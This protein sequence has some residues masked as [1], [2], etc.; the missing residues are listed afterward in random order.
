MDDITQCFESMAG[1][2]IDREKGIIAGV[3]VV[4]IGTAKGHGIKIDRK[5]LESVKAVADE[6]KSGVK[7]RFRHRKSGEYQSV[8]DETG[9]VIRNF[10]IDG[11]K[12]RGDL[13]LLSSIPAETREKML[14]MAEK[15]PDQ[16]GLSIDFS[17]VSETINGEKFARCQELQSIDLTDTPAANP[18]GLFSAMSKEI[19]YK[20]GDS[21]EHHE[22]C[23]CGKCSDNSKTKKMEASLE[24]LT[25]AIEALQ[26]KLT[27]MESVKPQPVTALTFTKTDG[28]TVQLSAQE[29]ASAIG[30]IET[31]KK[32]A[33]DAEKHGIIAKLQADC[34]VAMNPAIPGVA[35][36][37]EELEA[38]D[39]PMLKFAAANAQ[40]L[41]TQ[42]KAVYKGDKPGDEK[43]KFENLKGD[44]LVE[45]AFEEKYGN[46]DK[47]L[48]QARLAN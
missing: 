22:D 15:M 30:Q 2:V 43:K 18:N 24:S 7:F 45:A 40:V 3:S 6:F 48:E 20:N 37:L 28:A 27:A 5:T 16:F 10:S 38:L 1:G 11:N 23:M 44:A 12:L 21:G 47:M 39:L 26:A 13:H 8:V 14:E 29:I 4:T 25:K 41:P 32:S 9:G 36:K 42:A 35:M 46:L 34:R 17:G 31:F 33:A 19:K